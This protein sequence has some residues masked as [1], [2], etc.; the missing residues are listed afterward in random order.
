M[1]ELDPFTADARGLGFI[2][3]GEGG[4]FFQ[5]LDFL[6]TADAATDRGEVCECAAEPALIHIELA[7]GLSCFADGF[8][9]LL[10][11]ADEKNLA[12]V[13]DEALEE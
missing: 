9:S 8:L 2:D 1:E 4:G 12:A 13:F 7:S 11:G 6:E 10:L 5:S 3:F